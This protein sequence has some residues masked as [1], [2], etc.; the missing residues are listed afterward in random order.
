ML[1]ELLGLTGSAARVGHVY[2][3]LLM[4][5]GISVLN[6]V[7]NRLKFQ[8]REKTMLLRGQT[9]KVLV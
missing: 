4:N 8:N 9:Y 3:M 6:C 2:V 5:M 7:L 1:V